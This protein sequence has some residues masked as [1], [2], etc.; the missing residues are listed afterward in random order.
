MEVDIVDAASQGLGGYVSVVNPD[1]SELFVPRDAQVNVPA[2]PSPS[3]DAVVS[4]TVNIMS[5]R[6]DI[7]ES[8]P[9]LK[10]RSPS[11]PLKT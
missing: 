3:D 7:L 9:L 1:P 8:P 2:N 11:R 5:R 4:L 10:R 6:A